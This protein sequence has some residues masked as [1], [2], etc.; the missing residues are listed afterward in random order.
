MTFRQISVRVFLSL[1]AG[2]LFAAVNSEIAY[3]FLQT[4]KT[5]PPTTIELDIPPGTAAR[6]ARGESV[7][8]IPS[9]MLFVVGD[10]L[11]VK[12][13]DSVA[14]ELGPLFIPAGTSATMDLGKAQNYTF[15]CSFRPSKYIGLN[16]GL[17]LSP[18]IRTIGILEAGLT[19]GI[20]IALFVILRA[21][22]EKKAVT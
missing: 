4:G 20:L 15:V 18:T 16:V 7:Q 21:Y 8:S 10:V 1:L 13:E 5:R 17:P 22:P 14:H 12:N 2:L 11:L 9:N 6:V 3:H 19:T